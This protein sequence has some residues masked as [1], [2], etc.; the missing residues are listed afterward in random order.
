MERYL[1]WLAD[2]LGV[3]VEFMWD[4]L[5]FTFNATY[6]TIRWSIKLTFIFTQ[7]FIETF[8]D[9]IIWFYDLFVSI[10]QFSILFPSMLIA[11]FIVWYDWSTY[12]AW[13]YNAFIASDIYVNVFFDS[14]AS[15][16]EWIFWVGLYI[17]LWPITVPLTLIVLV[18]FIIAVFFVA[19]FW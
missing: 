5:R 14:Y 7:W 3:T 19:F 11:K 1:G 12:F 18:L 15:V 9:T 4:T 8:Y 10:M 6:Q 2:I 16:Y 17:V 13:T